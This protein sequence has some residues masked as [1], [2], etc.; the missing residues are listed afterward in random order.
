MGSFRSERA[1]GLSAQGVIHLDT[2]F[3]IRG[4]VKG[5]SFQCSV[6]SVQALPLPSP[7]DWDPFAHS[8]HPCAIAT[9]R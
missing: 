5:F 2:S 4:L 3:L 7:C 6:F 9:L 1:E 8:M